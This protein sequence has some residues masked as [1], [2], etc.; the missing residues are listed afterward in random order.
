MKSLRQLLAYCPRKRIP[1]ALRKSTP[2]IL[3]Q[4]EDRTMLTG[5]LAVLDVNTNVVLP[6]N[7]TT[8]NS[9]SNW[10]MSLQAQVS[11]VAVTSYSWNFASAPDA[12]SISGSSSYNVQFTW[13]SF[14][15][16]PRTDTISVTA[17]YSGGSLTQTFTYSVTATNSPAWSSA[18]TSA[19]TWPSVIAPDQLKGQSLAPAGPYAS[20]GLADG[21][22][23]TSFSL[24]SYNPNTSPLGLVYSGSVADP[25]PIF[26]VR[27]QLDPSQSLPTSVTAQLT[28]KDQSNNTVFTGSTIYYNPSS[29]NPGDWILIA[30]QANA[31]GLASG[32]YNWQISVTGNSTSNYSG[33]FNLIAGS[34]TPTTATANPF[35]PGWSLAGVDRLIVASGVIIQNPD[36]TSL[37][38]ASSGGSFVTPPGDFS[39]L[40]LSGGVYTDTLVDGTKINFNS[41]GQQTSVVDRDGNTTSYSYNG[42]NQ[43]TTV[44]DMN[45]QV[46][47]ISYSATT[48]LATSMS[49][50]ASRSLTLA[51]NGSNQLSSIT[52]PSSAVWTYS[53]DSNNNMT[54]IV[55]PGVG[56]THFTTT[57]SYNF[58]NRATSVSLPNTTSVSDTF[59]QLNGLATPGTG[60]SSNP[61]TATLLGSAQAV[62]TDGSSNQWKSYLDGLGFGT[63]VSL[64]EIPVTLAA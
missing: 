52:D 1:K 44:T 64:P 24:P 36:G 40:T 57:F 53:Y 48:H 43:L 31:S 34:T 14:T 49:D 30:L 28:L 50:P 42:S 2:L 3:E 25:Q 4:L 19:S 38:F 29:L 51:Y 18:P 55:D 37:W 16:A 15:G 32:R 9:F 46:N 23:Q 63:P 59:M 45:S 5:T 17:N 39:T 6:S 7:G 20:I 60:T 58:A 13:A 61:A 26:Q 22:V 21:S 11:G 8:I 56:G 33:S 47:T 41:S 10:A 12:G 54:G 35:G 62:F 27:Y